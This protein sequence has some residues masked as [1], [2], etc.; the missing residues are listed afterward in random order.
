LLVT[1]WRITLLL[2]PSEV[3][4]DQS[5][6]NRR[7]EYVPGLGF[8]AGRSAG[9]LLQLRLLQHGDVRLDLVE[10]PCPAHHVEEGSKI[11]PVVVGIC[12]YSSVAHSTP[13]K[14]KREVG[15]NSKTRREKER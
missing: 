12:K 1:L 8:A 15:S 5:F 10:L 3:L 2:I 7:S 9:L 11:M 6:R 4:P 13:W 14:F